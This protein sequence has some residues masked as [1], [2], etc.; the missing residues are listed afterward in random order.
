MPGVERQRRQHGRDLAL[1][2]A[3][4]VRREVLRVVGR[5]EELDPVRGKLRPQRVGPALGLLVEHLPRTGADER[6]LLLGRQAVGRDVLAVRAHLLLQHRH[7]NHEELVEV[8]PDD[9][10]ELDALEDRVPAVA[11]LVEHPLVERQPAELA[12]QVERRR[13][14]RGKGSADTA[15]S[16]PKFRFGSCHA[17]L[18]NKLCTGTLGVP[19]SSDHD[20]TLL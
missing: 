13:V 10:E 15:S 18:R 12:V 16:R 2:V 9:G 5:L 19:G 3:R 1:K 8:G 7:A 4:E 11:R 6:E 20:I 17:H 14:E